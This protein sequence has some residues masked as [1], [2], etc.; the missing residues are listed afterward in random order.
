MA[1]LSEYGRFLSEEEL[2]LLAPLLVKPTDK[3]IIEANQKNGVPVQNL[4]VLERILL[5][6]NLNNLDPIDAKYRPKVEPLHPYLSH[7]AE[8]KTAAELQLN[9]LQTRME[10]GGAQQWHVDEV[11]GAIDKID[12]LN[13]TLL[14]DYVTKHDQLAVIEE[15]GRH[16]SVETKAL[17]HPG[18]TSYDIVDTVRN[19]L[20]RKA[21]NDQIRVVALKVKDKFVELAEKAMDIP[22]AGRSHLQLAAPILYGRR[23]SRVAQLLA[24]RIEYLDAASSKLKGKIS[25]IV[26]TGAGIDMVIGK[27]QSIAFEKEVLQKWQMEPDYTASQIVQKANLADFAHGFA[28]LGLTI[29]NFAD[30]MRLLYASGLNEVTSRDNMNRLGGSSSNALKNNPINYENM[31]AFEF[32]GPATMNTVYSL[33][34]TD[35]ERDLKSSKTARV[36]PQRLMAYTFE[37]L[38]R[39]ASTLKQLD[40]NLDTIAANLEEICKKPGDAYTTVLRGEGF[41]HPTYGV[42]HSFVKE[43]GK[44]A[45]KENRPLFEVAMEDEY[46]AAMYEGLDVEKKAVLGGDMTQ[47]LGS[48][49]ERILE[50][51]AYAR[52]VN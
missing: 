22:A 41:V 18:T 51:L 9:L 14:E 39:A 40:L 1:D 24:E 44:V 42:G 37:T 7:Y 4:S 20:F 49:K 10:F 28:T 45:Q 15:I 30:D 2:A 19:Y 27:G 31:A 35:L 12:P 26:G 36:E 16:V 34:V 21:W 38:V 13:I 3:A 11:R 25:G 47:Y 32:I 52:N 29:A 50:N 43:I 46:F 6:N 17:L 23:F 48:E 8:F 33:L 5:H